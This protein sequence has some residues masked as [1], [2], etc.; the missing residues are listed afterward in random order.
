MYSTLSFFFNSIFYNL[1]LFLVGVELLNLNTLYK[2]ST[3][4][5]V[6]IS[7][8]TGKKIDASN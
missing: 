3:P 2:E 7:T 8:N 5:G 6:Q 4:P 1:F